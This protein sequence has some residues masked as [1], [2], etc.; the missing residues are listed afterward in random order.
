MQKESQ[1]EIFDIYTKM[2]L[3]QCV[4]Y[5]DFRNLVL[6]TYHSCSIEGAELTLLE[7]AKLI[8]GEMVKRHRDGQ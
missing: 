1:N 3:N 2:A 5:Y 4:S 7:T 6:M 8:A